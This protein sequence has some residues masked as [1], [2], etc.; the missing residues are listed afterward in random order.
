[1]T[2]GPSGVC[3]W[4]S[5]V[6]NETLNWAASQC[7]Y[8]HSEAMAGLCTREKRTE[9]TTYA[10]RH[11]HAAPAFATPP[12]QAQNKTCDFVN[13]TVHYDSVGEAVQALMNRYCG[14]PDV[15]PAAVTTP[16]DCR[17]GEDI[18]QSCS[19]R[20][21]HERFDWTVRVDSWS[22]I[23]AEAAGVPYQWVPLLLPP[24]DNLRTLQI[25]RVN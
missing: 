7:R 1:V 21:T 9:T 18:Q 2:Y 14:T 25:G 22:L 24:L 12:D 5:T 13:G 23:Y 10:G 3:H 4:R 15:H 11:G 16:I 8:C 19:L 6:K 17:H 20:A